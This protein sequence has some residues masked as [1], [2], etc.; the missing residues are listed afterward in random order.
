M[1]NGQGNKDRTHIA[2]TLLTFDMLIAL[3]ALLVAH[4]SFVPTALAKS[5]R[6]DEASPIRG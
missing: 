4:G 1:R 6:G 3:R 2:R 5:G